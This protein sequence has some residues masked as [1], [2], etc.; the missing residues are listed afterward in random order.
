MTTPASL[1][2]SANLSATSFSHQG[3]NEAHDFFRSR[4]IGGSN[5][6][7]LLP[8]PILTSIN[9]NTF[10]LE[11]LLSPLNN[12]SI[13]TCDSN[14]SLWSL[15]TVSI[16]PERSFSFEQ[17]SEPVQVMFSHANNIS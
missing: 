13:C 17:T 4:G 14:P 15:P 2:G 11:Q 3:Q 8:Q 6:L 7:P 10:G 1:K 5:I 12:I 16:T 9:P